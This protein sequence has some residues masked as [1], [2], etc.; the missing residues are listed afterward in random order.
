[1]SS[2][3]WSVD[4]L[5]EAIER[6]VAREESPANLDALIA[7]DAHDIRV[8]TGANRDTLWFALSRVS[9]ADA[10]LTLVRVGDIALTAVANAKF[11]RDQHEGGEK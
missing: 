5:I 10:A 4:D 3:C 6:L 9:A 11:H 2:P 1:M 7:N 8:V